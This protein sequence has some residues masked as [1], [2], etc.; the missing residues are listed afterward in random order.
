MKLEAS[1][2]ILDQCRAPQV[3]QNL[4]KATSPQQYQPKQTSL[5]FYQG[6]QKYIV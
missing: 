1:F 4:F 6:V 2:F 5:L 3:L